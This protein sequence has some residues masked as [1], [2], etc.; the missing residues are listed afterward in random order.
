MTCEEAR[1]QM[2]DELGHASTAA[3][4][5]HVASCPVCARDWTDLQSSFTS[6]ESRKSYRT[7]PLVAETLRQRILAEMARRPAKLIRDLPFDGLLSIVFG[8]AA[9]FASLLLLHS[10]GLL[11]GIGPL[12]LAAGAVGWAAVFILAFWTLLRR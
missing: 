1:Q 6:L 11:G 7:P 10:R 2:M 5:A 4:A 8:T 12:S 3:V 9:A